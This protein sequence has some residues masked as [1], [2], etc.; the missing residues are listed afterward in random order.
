MTEGPGGNKRY[1]GD[2]GLLPNFR[3]AA[4]RREANRVAHS[5][6]ERASERKEIVVKRFDFPECVRNR[7]GLRGTNR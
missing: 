3:F 4:I 5:M 2:F 1:Q 7:V 6:A